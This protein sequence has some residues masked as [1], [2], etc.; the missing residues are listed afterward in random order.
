MELSDGP[1]TSPPAGVRLALG[2]IVYDDGAKT[3]GLLAECA[4]TLATS[5]LRLGGMV[6]A[7]RTRPDRPRCDMYLED[8][9][10]GEKIRISVDLGR[11]STA[12]RLDTE[13]LARASLWGE[14]AL[15]EGVDLI[16]VNKFGKQEALG[17]GLRPVIADALISG[18]PVLMGVPRRN[19][20]ACLEFCGGSVA[21]LACER[22]AIISWCK[23]AVE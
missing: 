11:E 15:A 2:A 7:N 19:L 20:G 12:C 6:Q 4:R 22:E 16:I 18:V 9:F 1:R 14:R 21:Y 10:G 3:D 13:A 5:G 17:G 23:L 8:L